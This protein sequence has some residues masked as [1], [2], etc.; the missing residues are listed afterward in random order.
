MN[1][2][3][4]LG[5]PQK[6]T[7]ALLDPVE[8]LENV[9]QHEF[10]AGG[11]DPTDWKE[12]LPPFRYQ[13][14]SYW[15]TAFANTDIASAFQK[16]E[17]GETKLFSP[18]ELF[19]RT[20]G[21]LFG[22]YLL[23]AARGISESVVPEEYKPTPVPNSWGQKVYEEYKAGAKVNDWVFELGKKYRVKS[24]AIVKTDPDSLKAA[25]NVSPLSIAIPIGKGYWGKVAPKT[26]KNIST[27][28]VVLSG[29]SKDGWI[30]KDSLSG[31]PNFDGYHTLAW[32]YEILM[33]ISFIDLPNDWKEIQDAAKKEVYGGALDHYGKRR[34]M[35]RELQAA[36]S[37]KMAL[38]THFTLKGVLGA[39]WTVATN[40]LAYG[41]YSLTD[42]L[43]H[44]TSIRR[45]KGKIFD[46][47]KPRP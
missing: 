25:L 26:G 37:L 40:A 22:N 15:C 23:N 13:G 27:H 43:N 39:E 44:Y 21:Q 8:V 18:Y 38:K 4:W 45:G 34:D 20:N 47:N 11:G 42:L 12:Y 41:G 31:Y 46:L 32:D 14:S 16:K 9:P 30:I 33:A 2:R 29:Y 10:F 5:Y 36:E 17:A 6:E 7:G 3:R 28:N 1:W 24:Y 35:T 19:Y